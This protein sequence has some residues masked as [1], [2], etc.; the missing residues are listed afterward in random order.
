MIGQ[1]QIEKY[2]RARVAIIKL[3]DRL[4]SLQGT[5]AVDAAVRNDGTLSLFDAALAREG[6]FDQVIQYQS[7][8]NLLHRKS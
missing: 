1:K 3:G 6:V 5:M 2:A 7:D 4:S 8:H